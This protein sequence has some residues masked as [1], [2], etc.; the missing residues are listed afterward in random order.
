MPITQFEVGGNTLLSSAEVER[1][2]GETGAAMTIADMQAAA[3]RLQDAYAQA[4][5]GAVIVLLPEQ[6]FDD[7]LL[8]LQ[9]V[10]GKISQISVTGQ[11]G[12][13]RENIL[14]SLP[15]LSPGQ[16][17]RLKDL[18]REL[19]LANANPAKYTRVVLQAGQNPGEVQALATVEERPLPPWRMD[20]ENTGTPDTGRW[21]LAASYQNPNVAD[22]DMV[23]G[24][25]AVTS[26]TA[27]SR[28]AVL[29][30]TL[31]LPLYAAH[32]AIEAAL[33]AS[34][35]KSST[36]TTPAGDLR[37]AGDG[38]S[39]GARAI[40]LLPFVSDAKSQLSL[41][42]DIRRYRTQ[43]TLGDLGEAGC[44]AA[45]N[46][47]QHALPLTLG[48]TLYR[49]DAYL[50]NLQWVR[51]LAWGSAGRDSD[52]EAN[53]AGATSHYQLLRVN[54]QLLG[55]LSRQW[56]LKWRLDGQIAPRALVAAEQI[57]V[58]G[59]QTVRGY[60]ERELIGDSGLS[61]TLELSSRLD[62]LVG[63]PV[64]D[65][66]PTLS[67]FVDAGQVS[68]RLG[69]PCRPGHS[70]CSVWSA[71]LGA[72]WNGENR[73]FVRIEAARAGTRLQF[74]DRGDWKLHLALSALF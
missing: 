60:Q 67:L 25:R 69:T 53:R 73:F 59:S 23:L 10:E 44:G 28:V 12:F 62:T 42:L 63:Q 11:Y 6:T 32:T 19:L 45:R 17:P 41:G 20:L 9:V 18:D 74:T 26:P 1:A 46:N 57:G 27:P 24:V 72:A 30:S 21:R 64:S 38:L 34:N 4:G 29:G 16:T 15:A 36:N 3:Q 33:L 2:L 54:A 56:R 61:T 49:P 66:W 55:Q 31:R 7:G 43:C 71:G 68:N 47:T 65:A 5:H 48:Y 70:R 58:T 37:F 52:Y 22:R 40:W 14:R 35:T 39:A 13:S 8:R 51:N 50:L